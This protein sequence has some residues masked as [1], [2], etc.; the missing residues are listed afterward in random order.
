MKKHRSEWERKMERS[1]RDVF[2]RRRG[3]IYFESSIFNFQPSQFSFNTLILH[4]FCQRDQVL[5]VIQKFILKFMKNL[6]R[7]ASANCT[8]CTLSL[9]IMEAGIVGIRKMHNAYLSVWRGGIRDVAT[10]AVLLDIPSAKSFRDYYIPSSTCLSWAQARPRVAAP[11]LIANKWKQR[12][13]LFLSLSL[14]QSRNKN[15][16]DNDAE[17]EIST[18]LRLSYP[19]LSRGSI[20]AS[21]HLAELFVYHGHKIYIIFCNTH[22][23]RQYKR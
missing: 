9:R 11:R 22:I 17:Y 13:L 14:S 7:K 23:V 20:S 5:C 4:L 18:W 8:Y 12:K 1:T 19:R 2:A 6:E 21:T 10:T 15:A 16:Y 3:E